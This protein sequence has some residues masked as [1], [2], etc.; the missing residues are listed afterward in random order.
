MIGPL[1]LA[2]GESAEFSGSYIYRADYCGNDSVIASGVSICG[3]GVSNR[4]TSICPTVPT[5]PGIQVTK[6]CPEV[7]P[8]FGTP[9]TFTGTV[10]NTGNV[11]LIDV[12][13]VNSQPTNNSPVIGPINLA[14]GQTVNFSGTFMAPMDC[15]EITETIIATGRDLCSGNTVT[16]RASTAC[17]IMTT[18]RLVVVENCPVAPVA[19]G[20][21]Y[22]FTGSITNTGDVNLT[23]VMVFSI[24]SGGVRVPLLGPTELAPGEWARFTGSYILAAN[25]N[26]SGDIIEATGMDT[27]LGRTVTARANCAGPIDLSSPPMLTFVSLMDGVATVSWD[28][29]AGLTYTLQCKANHQD[30]IWIDIPG[31]VTATGSTASKTDV[32]GPS[33]RRFYRVL[34]TE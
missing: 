2:P 16:D 13:V 5:L 31:N 33:V 6:D 23:N 22:T 24:R 34:V 27:C 28:S 14:P 3:V 19:V 4:A 20:S 12:Y 11:T 1:T 15:C 17:P 10:R 32:V 30:P 7:P 9:Y 25:D 21:A 29:V 18:P 26:P 8:R